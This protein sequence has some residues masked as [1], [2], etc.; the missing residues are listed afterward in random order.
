MRGKEEGRRQNAEITSW[1]EGTLRGSRSGAIENGGGH[2]GAVFGKEVREVFAM[3]AT[4][5]L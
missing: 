3:P 1:T 4:P 5:N 2:E